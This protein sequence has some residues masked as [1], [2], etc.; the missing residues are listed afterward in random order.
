MF[1]E[2]EPCNHEEADTK[3]S[4]FASL[5]LS[6]N[7]VAVAEN[8]DG[9]ILLITAFAIKRPQCKWSIRYGGYKYADIEGIVKNLG[10]EASKL[11]AHYHAL[12]GCDVTS[13]FYRIG[14]IIPFKKAVENGTL[15]LISGLGTTETLDSE[16]LESCLDFIRT[17]LY[18]GKEKETYIETRVRLYDQQSSKAKRP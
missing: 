13:Y 7:I 3:I 6:S 18:K 9:F 8:C 2:E 11:L 16:C 15:E 10:Y 1:T 14:K 17:I 12:T 4:L 5:N